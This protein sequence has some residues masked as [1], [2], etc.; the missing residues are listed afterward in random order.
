M[1]RRRRAAALMMALVALAVTSL[2]SVELV[3]TAMLYHSAGRD[4]ALRRQA[5]LLAEAGVERAIVLRAASPEYAGETWQP[6][7]AAGRA[8]SPREAQV[9]IEFVDPSSD[10][11]GS[12]IVQAMI[13]PADSP[14]AAYRLEVPLSQFGDEP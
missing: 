11:S 10:H 5:Q 2:L 7:W 6:A 3:R 13:G 4:F 12:L 9:K 8:D 14:D 1:S